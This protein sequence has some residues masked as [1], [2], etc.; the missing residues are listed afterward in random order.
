[1]SGNSF[2]SS[3]RF[4]QKQ[5]FWNKFKAFFGALGRFF[6]RHKIITL[7]AVFLGGGLTFLTHI[8]LGPFGFL[9]GD[10]LSSTG[11]FKEK[12]YLVLLQNENELRPTGGFITSFAVVRMNFGRPEVEVFDSISVAVP[13]GRIEAPAPLERVFAT[14]PKYR[15]WVFHDAGFSPDFRENAEMAVRFLRQDPRFFGVEFDAVVAVDLHTVGAL[16]DLYAPFQ[17][18]GE[19]LSSA[20]FF[21]LLEKNSKDIDLHDEEEW[22]NRKNFFAPL[23]GE[24]MRRIA[25]SPTRWGEFFETLGQMADEKHVLLNFVDEGLQKEIMAKNWGGALPETDFF[26]VNIA[27]I[28]GRK[29]DRFMRRNYWSSFYVD[30]N[31]AIIEKFTIRFAHEGTHNLQSDRYEAYLRI[32]RPVGAKV[33]KSAGDF[34]TALETANFA[35]RTEFTHFVVLQPGESKVFSYE[36]AL[37]AKTVFDQPFSFVFGKQAG[38]LADSYN[39]TFR[40]ANDTS[41]LVSGCEKSRSTENVAMCDFHLAQDRKITMIWQAD[42]FPPLL[43]WAEFMDNNRLELR[44]SEKIAPSLSAEQIQV[45][46]LNRKNIGQTDKITV[47]SVE[48]ADLAVIIHLEGRTE[49]KGE[50]YQ[51][52]I[53]NLHDISGN[54]AT[55]NPFKATVVAK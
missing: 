35:N 41:F 40:G 13:E 2:F 10:V 37:P 21:Q 30:E 4:F 43:Q 25:S 39:L 15:G 44:F 16:V 46:D 50:Y 17:I 42:T 38:T 12:T 52:S 54:Y 36:I 55:D 28:G 11:F 20:N 51:V 14:D 18:N 6:W 9:T 47:K 48:I 24:L 31:G 27:N 22:K 7:I 32:L 26:A 8:L 33:L 34:E 45:I 29:A 3:H 23:A 53:P 49:Q 19:T 1:M 5:N